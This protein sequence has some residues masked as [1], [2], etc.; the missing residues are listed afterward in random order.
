MA[1]T[2]GHVLVARGAGSPGRAIVG[3]LEANGSRP[4]V[5]DRRTCGLDVPAATVDLSDPVPLGHAVTSLV[6]R[7]GPLDGLVVLPAESR[8]TVQHWERSLAEQLIELG[9]LVRTVLAHLS[10]TGAPVVLVEPDGEATRLRAVRAVAAEALTAQL[11]DGRPG[12]RVGRV[13]P[14]AP[15]EVADAVLE[16]LGV[17]GVL[18][19]R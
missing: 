18:G 14:G 3:A 10:P 9:G 6:H 16:Q 8:V 17:A 11:L 5:V 19:R 12:V 2:V 1:P 15:A 4:T 7:F 13:G